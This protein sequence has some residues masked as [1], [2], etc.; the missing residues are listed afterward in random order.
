[1]PGQIRD[2]SLSLYAQD[3]WSFFDIAMVLIF[4]ED[5]SGFLSDSRRVACCPSTWI[6]RSE[7]GDDRFCI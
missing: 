4:C 2:S 5:P 7:L 6:V 3:P 1:M